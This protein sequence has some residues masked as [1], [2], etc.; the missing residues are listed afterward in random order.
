MKNT[1]LAVTL[2]PLI[3]TLSNTRKTRELWGGS[4]LFSWIM[5]RIMESLIEQDEKFEENILMPSTHFLNQKPSE[6][7]GAGMYGDRM[8]LLLSDAKADRATVKEVIQNVLGETAGMMLTQVI[9][10]KKITHGKV[11]HAVEFVNNYFKIYWAEKELDENENIVI[12]MTPYLNTLELE[13]NY[14]LEETQNLLAD[15]LFK[16]NGSELV[17]DGFGAIRRPHPILPDLEIQG[18]PSIPEIAS[19]EFGRMLELK[20]D[21]GELIKK[22]PGISEKGKDAARVF[23]KNYKNENEEENDF[24]ESLSKPPFKERFRSY[25]KYIAIV[26]ADG[27]GMGKIVEEIAHKPEKLKKLQEGFLNFSQK[28][29]KIIND[30]GGAPVFAG[31]DDLM[32]FAPVIMRKK[33]A[34]EEQ[35]NIFNLLKKLDSEFEKSFNNYAVVPKLSFGLSITYAKFPMGEAL[36]NAR[37]LL[38]KKAKKFPG[39]NAVA[40]QVIKHS[41]HAFGSTVSMTSEYF[42]WLLGLIESSMKTEDSI[43]RSITYKIRENETLFD[44]IG[45]KENAVHNF[46]QN[47]FDEK[48]HSRSPYKEYVENIEKIIPAVYSESGKLFPEIGKDEATEKAR[49][50]FLK[51]NKESDRLYALLKTVHFLNEKTKED[52]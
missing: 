40:F 9:N 6:K 31:G 50:D 16:I 15:F 28:A 4:Y 23:Y 25:H 32:F 38:F 1:Y 37:D 13:E 48:I 41:G 27:D 35:D 26:Q 10:H 3:K 21:Y 42:T 39:K 18:F 36:V 22:F 47:S 8:Y 14:S 46:M 33:D 45:G 51:E 34:P 7:F 52:A 44:L 12:T 30:Y 43:L 2:G 24:F 19:R 49:G 11:E 29:G 20:E 17:E 5:R